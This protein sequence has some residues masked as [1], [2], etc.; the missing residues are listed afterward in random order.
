MTRT[1][2]GD[3]N[4]TQYY[5]TLLRFYTSTSFSFIQKI[6]WQAY[7]DN[8]SVYFEIGRSRRRNCYILKCTGTTLKESSVGYPALT[9]AFL[10]CAHWLKLSLLF[11]FFFVMYVV[12]MKKE[13]ICYDEKKSMERV[14]RVYTP[15][16]KYEKV[17]FGMS[18]ACT[19][20]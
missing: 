3:Y 5:S 18:S 2:N 17:V 16:P 7:R 15:Y 20:V 13:S 4:M 14:S 10:M 8:R 9:L 19:Y 1:V 6:C 12:Y 11:V